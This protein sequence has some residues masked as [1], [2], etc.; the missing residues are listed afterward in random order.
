MSG[1]IPADLMDPGLK[2][3]LM[4]AGPGFLPMQPR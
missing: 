4:R 2:D 1:A 3:R